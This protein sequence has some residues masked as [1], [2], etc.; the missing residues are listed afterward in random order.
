MAVLNLCGD[1]FRE[2]WLFKVS[3]FPGKNIGDANSPQSKMTA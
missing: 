2:N 1:N 3:G